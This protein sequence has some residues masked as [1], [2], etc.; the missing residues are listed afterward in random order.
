MKIKAYNAPWNYWK[1]L[2]KDRGW[3]ARKPF[4]YRHSNNKDY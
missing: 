2:G 3:T 1:H 4:T